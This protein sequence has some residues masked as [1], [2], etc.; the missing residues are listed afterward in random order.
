MSTVEARR[1][2]RDEVAAAFFSLWVVS[3]LFLDGWAHHADM[4]ETFWT[5]WHAVLY[6]GFAVGGL[7]AAVTGW[8]S[9]RA[10]EPMIGDRLVGYGFLAFLLGGVG[11]GAWHTVFGVEEDLEALLSPT[12]LLLMIGGLLLTTSALRSAWSRPERAPSLR[13]LLPALVG[14]TLAVATAG[15]FLQFASPFS[16]EPGTFQGAPSDTD[17]GLAVMG[18]IATTVL[19][20]GAAFVLR[21]RWRLPRHALLVVFT[22]FPLLMSGLHGFDQVALVLPA[23][24]GGAVADALL[25]RGASARVFGAAVPA[26]LWPA[27]FATYAALWGLDWTP[28]LWAGAIVF[29][30][31][32]GLGLSFLAVPAPAPPPAADAPTRDAADAVTLR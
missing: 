19:L 20:M 11:D 23:A 10:G 4:A 17:V 7:Y 3:G 9:R 14:T 25:A 15:F 6:S 13:T 1:E 30:A 24:L 18:L 28:D 16:P 31:L 29:G 21:A 2:R 26:V 32:T 5:P 12:H 27:W 8:L 22:G